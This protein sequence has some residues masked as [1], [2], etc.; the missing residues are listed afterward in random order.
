MY[1]F[2]LTMLFLCMRGM[3]TL[4][5]VSCMPFSLSPCIGKH[6][7][8][9]TGK[10]RRLCNVFPLMR[11][12]AVS[13]VAAA[14]TNPYRQSSSTANIFKVLRKKLLPVPA[15]PEILSK[16]CWTLS[17]SVHL[18]VDAVTSDDVRCFRLF[19]V[20]LTQ[21]TSHMSIISPDFVSSLDLYSSTHSG[22]LFRSLAS[23][24]QSRHQS[25]WL[26]SLIKYTS[27]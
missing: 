9:P 21:G 12:A 18:D 23:V 16:S 22:R 8:V 27:S 25:C 17:M 5:N 6:F 13:D 2:R 26:A 19:E 3:P 10:Q 14:W 1:I 7:L 20:Q 24:L 11:Y 4:L 15:A